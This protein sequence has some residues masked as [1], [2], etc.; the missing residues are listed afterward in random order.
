MDHFPEPTNGVGNGNPLEHFCLE[1][2]VDRG[3]WRATD[4]GVTKS[5]IQLSIHQCRKGQ[6]PFW[7]DQGSR[8]HTS[9]SDKEFKSPMY[10]N[11][12]VTWYL[13]SRELTS[14][15]PFLATLYLKK[16]GKEG[17]KKKDRDWKVLFSI[18]VSEN[19]I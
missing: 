19:A 5:G 14:D 4:H 3:A 17:E 9:V 15:F 12:G 10:K 2:S 13:A 16:E 11:Y 18:T 6:R 1:N 8:N 7:E